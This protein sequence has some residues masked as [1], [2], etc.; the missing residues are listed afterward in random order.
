MPIKDETASSEE[1]MTIMGTT[2]ERPESVEVPED[3]C[4]DDARPER[5]LKI[6]YALNLE[7]KNGLVRLLKEFEDVFAYS[8]EDMSGIEASS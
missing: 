8:V 3:I 2:L 5:T 7:L 1:V 6:G 4:L